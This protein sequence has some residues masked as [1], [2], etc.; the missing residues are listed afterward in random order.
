[1]GNSVPHDDLVGD[2][3][4]PR[5][6]EEMLEMRR[7]AAEL[8]HEQLG[9][10]AVILEDG[11]RVDDRLMAIE[12]TNA[13]DREDSTR[14][15]GSRRWCRCEASRVDTVMHV[16]DPPRV[17]AGADGGGPHALGGDGDQ[18]GSAERETVPPTG[19]ERTTAHLQEVRTPWRDHQWVE[20]GDRRLPPV[21]PHELAVE[22]LDADAAEDVAKLA[23]A[24]EQAED[25]PPTGRIQSVHLDRIRQSVLDHDTEWVDQVHVMPGIREPSDPSSGVNAVRI[26]N[27][28]EPERAIDASGAHGLEYD[29]KRPV[30]AAGA[31]R[32]PRPLCSMD[33]T[34]EDRW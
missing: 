18:V 5:P 14:A 21:A 1:M 16:L 8:H 31:G 11:D 33:G 12:R 3:A 28:A 25:R 15:P 23:A 32:R 7:V 2:A 29:P 10:E 27:E 6:I 17:R 30:L 4:L 9:R 20:P 26:G 34:R 13:P 24:P 19:A 22:D